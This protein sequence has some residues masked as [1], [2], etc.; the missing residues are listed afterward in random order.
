M[1]KAPSKAAGN[2]KEEGNSA[3]RRKDYA[4][5]VQCFT[6][7]LTLN[8]ADAQVATTSLSHPRMPAGIVC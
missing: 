5:A 6:R 7:S 1:S 2:A 8:P 4:E 3:F